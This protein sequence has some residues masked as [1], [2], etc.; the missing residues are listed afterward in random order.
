M[1]H[2]STLKGA[3]FTDSTRCKARRDRVL[4]DLGSLAADSQEKD[5]GGEEQAKHEESLQQA[6]SSE[7]Q[8]NC[9]LF[10]F[11]FLNSLEEDYGEVTGKDDFHCIGHRETE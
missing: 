9:L 1:Y 2:I 11:Y 3:V 8:S 5:T 4:R 6:K 7:F 10:I